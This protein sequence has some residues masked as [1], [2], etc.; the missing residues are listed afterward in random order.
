M[1]LLPL[2]FPMLLLLVLFTFV[3][4]GVRAT[5]RVVVGVG[6]TRRAEEAGP[7]GVVGTFDVQ[8]A[9]VREA[10]GLGAGKRGG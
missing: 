9:S 6:G 1:L 8:E 3:D 10:E 4:A 7:R 5:L 2:P